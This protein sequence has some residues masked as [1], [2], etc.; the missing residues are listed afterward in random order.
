MLN[1]INVFVLLDLLGHRSPRI[2]SYYRETDWMHTLMSDAD[3]RLRERGLIEVEEGEEGWFSA[4]RMPRG[5][6]GDDH[7]PVCLK[8]VVSG[9]RGNMWGLGLVGDAERIV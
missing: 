2:H 4:V 9:R 6:I 3:A 5:V 1:T 7:I 8:R